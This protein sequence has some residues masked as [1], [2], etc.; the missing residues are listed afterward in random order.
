[1]N[2]QLKKYVIR[3]P[4]DGTIFQLPIKREGAVVQPKEL[5]AEIAPKGT[6]L[7]FKGQIPTSESESIRSGNPHK[8]AKLKFDEYP[9][10]DYGVVQGKLSRVSPDFKVTQTAQGN[11]TTY[12]LEIELSQN[13]IQP[14][15]KCISFKSGQPATAEVIIRQRRV[16][17]LLI[18]PF[19]KLQKG[20][21][22]L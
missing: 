7:V 5:I 20:D 18:D 10:Q 8:E 17:D 9:F 1:M 19:K 15:S 22:K 4:F 13:C 14:E 2:E 3:A 11:L 12:D 16:I 6:H 21:L